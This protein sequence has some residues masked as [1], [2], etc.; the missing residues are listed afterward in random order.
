VSA[1]GATHPK[2][3]SGSARRTTLAGDA[4]TQS[5]H[6]LDKRKEK[7]GHALSS[8][9]DSFFHLH[10]SL[11]HLY[12]F[13]VHLHIL[14]EEIHKSKREIHISPKETYKSKKNLYKTNPRFNVCSAR[15]STASNFRLRLE[16]EQGKGE[17]EEPVRAWS[18]SN[19]RAPFREW[20]AFRLHRR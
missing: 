2:P 5:S 17:V 18:K 14:P 12:I 19:R 6:R 4:Q 16:C 13:L 20:R 3:A 1:K 10:I 11:I 15:S 8:G 9:R 7:Q